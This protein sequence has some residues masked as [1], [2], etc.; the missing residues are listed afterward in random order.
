MLK[1]PISA[2]CDT[3]CVCEDES[4]LALVDVVGPC[5]RDDGVD[6]VLADVPAEGSSS[7]MLKYCEAKVAEVSDT[8]LLYITK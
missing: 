3:L 8:L 6:V 7:V 5:E 4:V 2:P 1:M